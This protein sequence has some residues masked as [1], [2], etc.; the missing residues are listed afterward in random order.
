VAARFASEAIVVALLIQMSFSNVLFR[1]GKIKSPMAFDKARN[2]QGSVLRLSSAIA[3]SL[4]RPF[5]FISETWGNCA[6]DSSGT[7]PL[8]CPKF[9]T[10]EYILP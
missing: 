9:Q 6:S 7:K 3:V 2:M 5:H 10:G 8:T 4:T 1:F